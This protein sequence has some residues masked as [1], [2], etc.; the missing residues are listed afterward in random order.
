M[1]LSRKYDASSKNVRSKYV[2]G[3]QDKAEG[4]EN[5]SRL[6]A[7]VSFSRKSFGSIKGGATM[8]EERGPGLD[9]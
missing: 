6:V 7:R 9:Y 2:C 1:L 5:W 8:K 3:K 4:C